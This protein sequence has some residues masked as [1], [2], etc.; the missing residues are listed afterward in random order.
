M[1]YICFHLSYNVPLEFGSFE[2]VKNTYKIPSNFFVVF[3]ED[4]YLTTV[5]AFCLFLRKPTFYSTQRFHE[6]I[7]IY[8]VQKLFHAT[9]TLQDFNLF[10]PFIAR[11]CLDADLMP[12]DGKMVIPMMPCVLNC[13]SFKIFLI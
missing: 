5:R 2:K 7:S 6:P 13:E 12:I 1:P 11:C 3:L 8:N 9:P 4:T 10:D